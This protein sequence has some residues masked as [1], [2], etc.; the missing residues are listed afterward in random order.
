MTL[1]RRSHRAFAVA[2]ALLLAACV[3]PRDI[4][5]PVAGAVERSYPDSAQFVLAA[6][7][8][9]LVDE[10]IDIGLED[11]T[12]GLVESRYEDVGSLR[13]SISREGYT[14]AERMVRFRFFTQ[15][16]LGG[17]RL[18]GEAVYRPTMTGGRAMERMVP[19]D[20]AAREV[21]ARLYQ[22]VDDQ[23][24]QDRAKRQAAQEGATRPPTR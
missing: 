9:A 5:Q 2:A 15:G 4:T 21:L 6:V 18:V 12:K 3:K 14:D 19:P 23:L 20:H 7:T 10:T 8:R 11:R 1:T 13:S 22:R 24:Q 17:T 16:M